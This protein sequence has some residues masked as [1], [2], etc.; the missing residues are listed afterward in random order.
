MEAARGRYRCRLLQVRRD[1]VPSHANYWRIRRNILDG[2]VRRARRDLGRYPVLRDVE[3]AERHIRI[4]AG[5]DSKVRGGRA[6][7]GITGHFMDPETWGLRS[8]TIAR[9]RWNRA[10]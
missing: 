2:R 5:S 9:F 4:Q 1:G 8:L 3:R 7:F 10:I 6:S